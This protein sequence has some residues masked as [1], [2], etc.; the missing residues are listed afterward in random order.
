MTS[1]APVVTGDG[2]TMGD[3]LIGLV[4]T[5]VPAIVG[6]LLAWLA[7]K[8]LDLTQYGNAV[9]AWLVPVVI[10]LY[11]TVARLLERKWPV[12]GLLLGAKKQAVYIDQ[13][14]LNAPTPNEPLP[15]L[16]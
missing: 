14:G 16:P 7:S 1:P 10:G 8:G 11:Y 4:R 15:R 6:T 9:N 13:N 2:T 5:A 12:F 3:V